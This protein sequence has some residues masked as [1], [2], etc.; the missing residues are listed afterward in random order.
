MTLSNRTEGAL[1]KDTAGV[2]LHFFGTLRKVLKQ[3]G[4]ERITGIS[5]K[6]RH[7]AVQRIFV[8][9]KPTDRDVLDGARVVLENEALVEAWLSVLVGFAVPKRI[10]LINE[11][12]IRGLRHHAFLVQQG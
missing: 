12:L 9:V 6:I 10:Q 7:V 3:R 2:C 11:R 4:N 8:L 1:L 5:Q